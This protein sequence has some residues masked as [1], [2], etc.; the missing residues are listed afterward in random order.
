MQSGDTAIGYLD[1][2]SAAQYCSLSARTLDAAKARGELPFYRFS[3]RR[4][5][6]RRVDLDKWLDGM[7][8]DISTCSNE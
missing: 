1:K 4:V 2:R 6:F 7:R 5:L 3:S 8:V